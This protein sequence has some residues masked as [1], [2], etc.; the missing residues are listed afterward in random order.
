MRMLCVAACICRFIRL[1]AWYDD[2]LISRSADIIRLF[3]STKS[4]SCLCREIIR[5]AK[6]A[7]N[8]TTVSDLSSLFRTNGEEFAV[9]RGDLRRLSYSKTVF[10]G[11]STPSW[12]SSRCS[13]R[14]RSRMTSGF[15]LP[16]L[17]LSCFWDT[18]C[19]VVLKVLKLFSPK[20]KALKVLE[21]RT[22]PWKSLNSASKTARPKI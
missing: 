10:G 15:F 2:I 16:I 22:G 5:C 11:V 21:N 8:W 12:E 19:L 13:H 7:S 9:S 17:L 4:Q 1:T 3:I 6:H 14:P 18:R 20:F